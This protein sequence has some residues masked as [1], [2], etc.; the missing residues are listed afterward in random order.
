MPTIKK[1]YVASGVSIT[2]PSDL[3]S[4]SSTVHIGE[5]VDDAAFVSANGT[6]T[7]GDIYINTTLKCLRL[8]TGS[9][10]RS[11][12]MLV[13]AADPTKA[14]VMDLAGATAGTTATLDFN[15][16][17]S[18][19]YTFPDYAG[20]VALNTGTETNPVLFSGATGNVDIGHSSG[21]VRIVGNFEVQGTQTIFN[22]TTVEVEDTNILVN[23]GG[24][25][26][27]A[28]G[29]GLTVERT[30]TSGSL[31]YDSA[32]E[33]KWKAG[34]LGSEVGLVDKST[35][36]TLTNKSISGS[37]NTITNVSLTTAVTGTLPTANGGTGV[38]GSA[39]FPSSGTVA[40]VPS[41]GVV[42]SN[43]SVLS[44][45]NVDLSSEV[46][47]TLPIA[48]GGTGQ[49]TA[50]A[51]LNALLPSQSGN[52]GK[53]LKTDG[54]NTSWDV[55]SGG[56]GTE[57]VLTVT[58]ADYTV[59]DSDGYTTI[60]FSTGNTPRTLTLPTLA[61]NST[62]KIKVKKTDSGTGTVTIDGEGA[63]TIDDETTIVINYQYEEVEIQ[64]T[65]T[66]WVIINHGAA[67]NTRLG[68]VK[69]GKV[70]G[71]TS[72]TAVTTG[73]IGEM[74]LGSLT[75]RSSTG[76]YTYSTRTTTTVT[77]AEQELV[78]VTLNK[79]IY[80]VSARIGFYPSGAAIDFTGIVRLT[81]LSQTNIIASQTQSTGAGSNLIWCITIP[82]HIT[83]DST[84]VIFS[85]NNSTSTTTLA[86]SHEC[87]AVRIA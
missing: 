62:R 57:S 7:G 22:T 80:I 43:G 39:V 45:S 6:A 8:Y 42:K 38:S 46:S 41:S 71:E 56:A 50:N 29:A 83:T 85:G 73:F 75:Q 1:L 36:Q 61:D 52:N 44:A 53:F 47:G 5:Y 54:T 17:V 72:G 4:E 16:T 66:Q 19:A 59:L 14:W 10:W 63:E 68:V 25:D 69:G 49:I 48:N 11:V 81:N 2:A 13:D 33:T 21:T 78:S 35:A 37:T 18:R 55:A 20:I 3:T 58:S 70:P 65:S 40:L 77:N 27:T 76:G 64:A 87:W 24:N 84:K 32:E 23:N 28:Q 15:Q 60:L 79:G 86:N 34:S 51:A 30:G 31:V 82:I 26:A 12:A 74:A 9:A 67:T